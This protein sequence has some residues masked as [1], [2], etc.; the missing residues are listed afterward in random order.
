MPIHNE[1]KA[2]LVKAG[3]QGEQQRLAQIAQQRQMQQ[4][5]QEQTQQAYAQGAQ[6][7]HAE[8]LQKGYVVGADDVIKTAG[9][10]ED[11]KPGNY[12]QPGNIQT[13]QEAEQ[14]ADQ[15][16]QMHQAGD[17]RLPQ[18]AQQLQE[19]AQKGDPVAVETVALLNQVQQQQQDTAQQQMAV[20]QQQQAGLP[21]QA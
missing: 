18:I 1:E 17:K 6:E 12:G 3:A 4:Q 14:L 7:G 15:I 8:G 9:L 11:Q 13:R 5:A 19:A 16:V 21:Q 20:Q 2:A 10:P